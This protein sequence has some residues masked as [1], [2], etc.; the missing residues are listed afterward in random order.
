MAIN[1]YHLYILVCSDNSLYTGITK[2]LE[3]RIEEHNSSKLGAKYTRPRRPV[4]LV[5]SRKFRNRA[6]AS[7]EEFRIKALPRKKKLAIIENI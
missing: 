6:N 5:Y 4:R 3:R 7:K 1:M 2:N